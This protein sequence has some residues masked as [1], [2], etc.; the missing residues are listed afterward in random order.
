MLVV[1]PTHM[2]NARMGTGSVRIR[3]KVREIRH[4]ASRY[5]QNS[6]WV[7]CLAAVD[8]KGCDRFVAHPYFTE[9]LSTRGRSLVG[10]SKE[11][12]PDA[13]SLFFGRNFFHDALLHK[14]DNSDDDHAIREA[15]WRESDPRNPGVRPPHHEDQRRME[16]RD[17]SDG[18]PK[19]RAPS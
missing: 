2:Q 15:Y 12:S 6:G 13:L 3:R 19:P 18:D 9:R 8:P 5:H 16:C 17:N 7:C 11:N 10:D 4:L 1:Q 14:S